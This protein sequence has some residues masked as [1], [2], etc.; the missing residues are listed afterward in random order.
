MNAIELLMEQHKK[1]AKALETMSKADD[2]DPAMLRQVG[3][4]L[5]AHMVIEEHVF[6]PRVRELMEDV[7]EESFEEHAVA[8]FELARAMISTGEQQKARI[9]VLK[10]LVEHHVEEEEKEMFPKVRSKLSMDELDQLGTK[11][12]VMFEKAVEM[13]LDELVRGQGDLGKVTGGK[14]NSGTQ[15]IGGNASRRGMTA[16][17]SR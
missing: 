10:E 6:Y 15:R 5:V 16:S 2:V 12:R 13:G 7:I 11:M 17:Q 1:V 14:R 4:E 3:D 8:R 9:T